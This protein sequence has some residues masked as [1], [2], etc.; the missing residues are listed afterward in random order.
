MLQHVSHRDQAE[1]RRRVL[2]RLER[3]ARHWNAELFS[4]KLC[5]GGVQLQPFGRESALFEQVRKEAGA[6]TD[7]QGPPTSAQMRC[8]PVDVRLELGA[9]CRTCVL[10]REQLFMV[11]IA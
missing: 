11:A 1:T 8:N 3:L 9:E 10:H 5:G 7:V 4:G 6:A 2:G